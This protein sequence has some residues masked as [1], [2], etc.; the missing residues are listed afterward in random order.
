MIL[1]KLISISES[2][3][4]IVFNDE[5]GMETTRAAGLDI[6]LGKIDF[7]TNLKNRSDSSFTWVNCCRSW[8][9]HDEVR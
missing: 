8:N 3:K 4:T 6:T 9:G 7:V 1:H 5:N 2:D